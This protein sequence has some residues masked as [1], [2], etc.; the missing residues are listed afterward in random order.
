MKAPL[1]SEQIARLL[2]GVAVKPV[3]PAPQPKR[4]RKAYTTVTP[5]MAAEIRKTYAKNSTYTWAELG[6]KFG[7]SKSAARSVIINEP[8]QG[9]PKHHQ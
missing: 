1:T 3:A 8:A 9:S 4:K 6:K 5:S 7:L 2:G